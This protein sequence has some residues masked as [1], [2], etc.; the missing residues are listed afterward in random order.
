VRWTL[1]LRPAEETLAARACALGICDDGR[2]HF[3]WASD[4]ATLQ[5]TDPSGPPA[6]Q[7]SPLVPKPGT[8]YALELRHD[9]KDV[10]LVRDGD[11]QATIAAG[12]RQ[13]GALFLCACSD[14]PLRIER[15]EIECELPPDAFE[16]VKRGWVE[17]GLARF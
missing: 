7:G 6:A 3:V 12:Q 16:R 11:A 5:S 10:K 4:L 2:E 14:A 15:L 9:G 1:E 17:R 8:R 13:V